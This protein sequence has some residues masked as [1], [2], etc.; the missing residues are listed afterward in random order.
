MLVSHLGVF[1]AWF[2]NF[3]RCSEQKLR[4]HFD[5]LITAFDG[6]DLKG[7]GLLSSD[8][9][10]LGLTKFSPS[11]TKDAAIG[12]MF[13]ITEVNALRDTLLKIHEAYRAEKKSSVRARLRDDLSSYM[14]WKVLFSTFTGVTT[15]MALLSF[16]VDLWAM[17]GVLSFALNFIPTLGGLITSILT[18]PMLMLDPDVDFLEAVVAFCC[19]IGVHALVSSA[20]EPITFGRRYEVHPVAVVVALTVWISLWGFVGALVSTPFLIVLRIVLQDQRHPVAQGLFSLIRGRPGEPYS[21]PSASGAPP[22]FAI[23]YVNS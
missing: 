15:A 9:F 2:C 13:N 11:P 12:S 17:Y 16:E 19:V 7:D 14:Y 4:D 1:F 10:R 6:F 23:H 18:I 21:L 22:H 20:I 5:V 3:T 8:Q